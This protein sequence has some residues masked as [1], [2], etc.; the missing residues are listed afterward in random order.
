MHTA[1]PS[2]SADAAR[3]QPRLAAGTRARRPAAA[4]RTCRVT[5]AALSPRAGGA[6]TVRARVAALACRVG[7]AALTRRASVN[8]TGISYTKNLL[9]CSKLPVVRGK[10]AC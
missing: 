3:G 1:R 2:P 10:I 9:K 4:R 7:R 8:S 6:T 5:R